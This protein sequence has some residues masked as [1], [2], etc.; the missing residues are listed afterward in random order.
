MNRLVT[1]IIPSYRSKKLI[2]S[3]LNKFSKEIKI[4]IIE[5][6]YDTDFKI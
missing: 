2:L 4:I 1:I 3:H 5:N 6:S